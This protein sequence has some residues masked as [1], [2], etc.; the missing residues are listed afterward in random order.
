MLE[1]KGCRGTGLEGL[2]H[3]SQLH[4]REEVRKQ[5]QAG[6]TIDVIALQAREPGKLTF[7][8]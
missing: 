2:V 3:V 6:D 1:L 8:R 5:Y 7:S 4:K